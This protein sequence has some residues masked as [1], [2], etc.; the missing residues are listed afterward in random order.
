MNLT[1]EQIA[2]LAKIRRLGQVNFRKLSNGEL[3]DAIEL[4]GLDLI[5]R[6]K[7]RRGNTSS[8]LVLTE[9]G[10]A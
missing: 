9:E 3:C 7:T 6:R 2:L 10:R 4:V 8:F 1:N 5:K